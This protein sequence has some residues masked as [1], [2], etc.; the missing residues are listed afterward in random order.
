V[1]AVADPP[2]PDEATT[3]PRCGAPLA[4]EQQWCVECGAAARTRIVRP[5]SW[6]GP[7]AL[8]AVLVALLGAGA[9][10]AFVEATDHGSGQL[11][12]ATTPVASTPAPA[13]AAPAPTATTPAPGTTTPGTAATTP[14]SGSTPGGTTA[15]STKNGTPA[16]P[17]GKAKLQTWP[18][19]VAAYTV[20]LL[21]T[22]D[23]KVARTT[24]RGLV[25][26]GLVGLAHSDDFAGMPPGQWLVFTG[27]FASKQQADAAALLA[28]RH[29]AT[30]ASVQYLKPKR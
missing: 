22:P 28:K 13:P 8:V 23:K 12:P 20:L 7:V 27:T 16:T 14:G 15:G 18:T 10:V 30:A 19:G 6:R 21:S 5:P 3:C 11:R 24:A 17:T 1:S 29:G 4:P 2:R 25:A 9:A 26:T